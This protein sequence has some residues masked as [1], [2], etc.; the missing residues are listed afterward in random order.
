[1]IRLCSTLILCACLVAPAAFAVE[2]WPWDLQ[3][4][5]E[6]ALLGTGAGL[7]AAGWLAGRDRAPLTPDEL[8]ALD[9]SRVN[10]FDRPATRRW[11]EGAD[12]VSDL[13]VRG[14][15]VAPVGQM[16]AGPGRDQA[17]RLA[18]MYV[19]T[20][21]LNGGA[22]YALKSLFGRT[23]PYVHNDDPRIPEALKRDATARR[24]WPSGHTSNAFAAAVFFAA[25]FEKLQPDSPARGWVWGGCLGAAA[26]TGVLRYVAGRHYPT[27]I[28]A[29]AALGAAVGWLVPRWHEVEASSSGSGG[30]PV[31]FAIRLGF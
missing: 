31:A 5:R 10:A 28:L 15:M 13:L 17:G 12:Q 16:V 9:A 22:T 30:T 27:D 26:T 21:L 19:E 23:R 25:T 4:G 24:S 6:A 18:V 14:L 3:D 1:M 8:L 11:S 2:P 7:F 29:G 20:L